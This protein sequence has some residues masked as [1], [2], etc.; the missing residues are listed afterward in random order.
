MPTEESEREREPKAGDAKEG[1]RKEDAPTARGSAKERTQ[2]VRRG[3]RVCAVK[4]EKSALP[5]Q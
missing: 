5:L 2:G 3:E 4:A 1:G